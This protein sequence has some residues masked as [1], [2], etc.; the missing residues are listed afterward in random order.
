MPRRNFKNAGELKDVQYL[1]GT[2]QTIDSSTDTCTVAVDGSV[3]SALFFY[4]CEPDSPL[5]DNGAIEGGA[6]G[7][8][9]GDVVVVQVK[10][11]YG[12]ALVV[13]HTDGVRHCDKWF[14]RRIV[15]AP[16][17][18]TSEDDLAA[19]I[20]V[21]DVVQLNS[22]GATS[23][24]IRNH[25]TVEYQLKLSS[26]ALAG[27]ESWKVRGDYRIRSIGVHS[28]LNE[29]NM[30]GTDDPGGYEVSVFSSVSLDGDVRYIYSDGQTEIRDPVSQGSLPG[31]TW[32]AP[33]DLFAQHEWLSGVE[34]AYLRIQVTLGTFYF[35]GLA[36][37]GEEGEETIDHWSFYPTYIYSGPGFGFTNG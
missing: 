29:W 9:V 17:I 2:I 12:E 33:I 23:F 20:S 6:A 34:E 28:L 31:S 37:G 13:A 10:Y 22:G 8:S 24:F 36:Y 4:H 1:R 25:A 3:L 7:F 16:F 26:T 18:I 21:N 11:D 19:A 15:P 5:R 30:V 32:S 14:N 27:Y 35:T